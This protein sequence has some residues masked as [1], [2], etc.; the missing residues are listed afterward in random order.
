MPLILYRL[1]LRT[2]VNRTR[3]L[4]LL[5]LGIVGIA[6]AFAVR[7]ND[8]SAQQAV[9][10]FNGFGFALLVPVASLTFASAALG[11]L[12]EDRTL[13][14]LWLRPIARWQIAAAAAAAS[15]T[16]VIPVV[17]TPLVIAA[18]VTGQGSDLVSGAL[19]ATLV[20]VVAYSGLFVLLGMVS[21]RPMLWGLGYILI[22]EGFIAR[23]GGAANN[24]AIRTYTRSILSD[25]TGI[26]LRLANESFATSV[27]VP[28]IV[29]VVA[30][31]L[32]TV[33]LNR[34]DVA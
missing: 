31:G 12:V 27:I 19:T 34:R 25:A 33:L 21:R 8:G 22:W 10:F 20:G 24:L 7:A 15:V 1:F 13:V 14:Y 17:A 28:L 3:I 30:L 26:R 23:A 5:G 6:V 32:T 11:D 2:Q 18:A 9:R 4:A 16:V 29:A